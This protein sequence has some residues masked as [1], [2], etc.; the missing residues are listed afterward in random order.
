[1]KIDIPDVKDEKAQ[2]HPI[3]SFSVLCI[4]NL[5][6]GYVGSLTG[7][8]MHPNHHRNDSWYDGLIKPWWTPPAWVF[9][10]VWTVLYIMIALSAWMVYMRGKLNG[11][12]LTAYIA[13]VNKFFSMLGF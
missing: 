8:T 3:L 2:K 5:I 4:G 13:Q 7:A 11:L 6:G 10:P 1:M 12:R 9:S